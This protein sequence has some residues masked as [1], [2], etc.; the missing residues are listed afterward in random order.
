MKLFRQCVNL[1]SQFSELIDAV[2]L[3]GQAP[4]D[5]FQLCLEKSPILCGVTVIFQNIEFDVQFKIQI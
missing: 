4:N 3:P 1:V 2:D 5:H